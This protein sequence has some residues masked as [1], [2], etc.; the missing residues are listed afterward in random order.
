MDDQTRIMDE[1]TAIYP[2][3][4]ALAQADEAC[5]HCTTTIPAGDQF[6]PN[7]GYQ[8]NTWAADAVAAGPAAEA[9]ATDARFQLS[10]PA[11]NTWPLPDGESVAGRSADADITV[12]DGYISRRHAVFT[13][14]GESVTVTDLGSANGTFIGEERLATDDERV[15]EPGGAVRLGQT[16][17]ILAAVA[18]AAV[19][20]SAPEGEETM[21]APAGDAPA[22]D[23]VESAGEDISGDLTPVG[24]LAGTVSPWR[25]KRVGEDEF[26]DLPSGGSELGRKPDKCDIVV[27]GDGY[28]SGK[29]ARIVA[30]LDLLEV[31]DLGSTNGTYV[32]SE[33][34]APDAVHELKA[35][36]ILRLGQTDLEVEYIEP[37]EGGEDGDAGD[38]GTAPGAAEVAAEET[39][40]T[41]EN[42][43]TDE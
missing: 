3:D 20:E 25:L 37:A 32:N 34:V 27:R 24:M 1:G 39:A 4:P 29:H 35:G 26:F 23:T 21:V 43:V 40:D 12:P 17:L 19:E 36:D 16:E 13:V 11:G 42:D 30:S 15:L 28:L 31:T 7:C 5:P 6:C 10:D 22:E 14:A 41:G 38:E 8:R 33:R 18:P 9:A 2:L